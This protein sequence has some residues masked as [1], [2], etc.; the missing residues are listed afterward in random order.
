MTPAIVPRETGQARTNTHRETIIMA[1]SLA[2]KLRLTPSFSFARHNDRCV[3]R[4]V[5]G[6]RIGSEA[7]NHSLAIDGNHLRQPGRD[8]RI[9]AV[10]LYLKTGP[11]ALVV[12]GRICEKEVLLA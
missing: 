5:A 9:D 2:T 8:H 1:A 10:A 7:G 12:V 11:V 4:S 3:V 6:R